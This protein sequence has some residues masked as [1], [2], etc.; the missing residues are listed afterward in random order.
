MYSQ[1]M[2]WRPNTPRARQ[3]VVV[4]IIRMKPAN[5]WQVWLMYAPFTASGPI[6][7]GLVAAL[8]ERGA[9]DRFLLSLP[10]AGAFFLLSGAT[11]SYRLGRRRD[12]VT[13]TE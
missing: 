1:S 10:M 5:Y 7:G 3:N 4:R 11:E 12:A 2:P 13:L 6:I 9:A 8:I